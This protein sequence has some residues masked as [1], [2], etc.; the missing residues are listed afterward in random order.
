MHAYSMDLWRKLY[1]GVDLP[2]PEDRPVHPYADG[3][4]FS[5]ARHGIYQ[6]KSSALS[7][8]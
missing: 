1:L 3:D 8:S 2:I 7:V 4:C 5:S 6:N